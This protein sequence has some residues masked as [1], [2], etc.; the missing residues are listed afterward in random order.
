MHSDCIPDPWTICRPPVQACSPSLPGTTNGPGGSRDINSFDSMFKPQC[1]LIK[2]IPNLPKTTLERA[3]S[4]DR[5]RDGAWI[6]S[7]IHQQ[8]SGQASIYITVL[9]S[10]CWCFNWTRNAVVWE[11]LFLDSKTI[12]LWRCKISNLFQDSL[13]NPSFG[14]TVVKLYNV[15]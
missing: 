6:I 3:A 12:F 9:C 7:L 8:S 10:P 11:K 13:H 2:Y 15:M 1:I 4:F 14:L 5:H